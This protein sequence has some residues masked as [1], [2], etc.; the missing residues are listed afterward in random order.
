M[1]FD[2]RSRSGLLVGAAAVVVGSTTGGALA[3]RREPARLPAS[4]PAIRAVAPP[5]SA[6]TPAAPASPDP[7]VVAAAQIKAAAI[8]FVA[9]S[10]DHRGARCPDAAAL[11]AAAADPWS[12]SLRVLCADQPDDQIAGILSLGPDGLPGTADD[13]ASWT[14]GPDVTDLLRG[15][16]WGAGQSTSAKRPVGP[17]PHGAGPRGTSGT[18]ST[19]PSARAVAGGNDTDGDGI[20]DRR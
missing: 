17:W 19:R 9:W 8:R 2:R 6:S 14:L 10:H 11:G 3:L 18:R 15:A 13:V 1:T 7:R 4:P 20:P 12:H 16:P 5:A